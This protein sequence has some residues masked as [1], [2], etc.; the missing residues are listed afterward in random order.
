MKKMICASAA[1]AAVIA[2]P[3]LAQD[4]GGR[5]GWGQREQTRQ[6]AQQ[7]A[8]MMFQ[9]LDTNRDGVVTRA[10]AEQAAAR[11]QAERGDEGGRGGGRFQRIIGQVFATTPSITLQQFEGMM[12]ARFDA[13][14]VNHDGVL[15]ATERE[16]ARAGRGTGQGTAPAPG[17][18]PPPRQ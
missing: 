5:G 1:V 17:A 9:L 13:Q 2:T 12:L 16:Q 3:A 6:Q 8:D 15:S 11:F 10:E 7:R 14:D 4:A 18:V